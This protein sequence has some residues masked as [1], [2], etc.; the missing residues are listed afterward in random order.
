MKDS[1]M[2]SKT[3][4]D[5]MITAANPPSGYYSIVSNSPFGWEVG[6][7]FEHEMKGMAVRRG[8]RVS[9][10]HINAG[11][12]CHGGM[13]MTFADILIAAAVLKATEPPFV[14]VKLTTDFVG[15]A[16]LYAWVEGEAEVAAIRDGFATVNGTIKTDEA[17]VATISSVF[18]CLG[19]RNR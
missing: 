17:I 16:P 12:V 7:F 5:E 13:L 11:G 9:E 2:F 14:T 15:P 3:A 19:Q 8:F 18:R 10:N 4:T 1:L 6:P